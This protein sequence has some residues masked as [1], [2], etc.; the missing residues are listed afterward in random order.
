MD[1]SLPGSSVYGILQARIL[2]WLPCPLLGDLLNPGIE[3]A[4]LVSSI[5]RPVLYYLCHLGSHL[6]SSHLFLEYLIPTFT[7]V[8]IYFPSK[9]YAAIY[10]DCKP[11]ISNVCDL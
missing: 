1:Y 3:A 11:K 7:Y 6:V 5:S 2:E 8:H 10:I 9:S 4:S